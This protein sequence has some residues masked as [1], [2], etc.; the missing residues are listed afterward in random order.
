MMISMNRVFL[1]VNLAPVRLLAAT[2]N[3]GFTPSRFQGATSKRELTPKQKEVA[4]KK[5]LLALERKQI[6][7]DKKKLASLKARLAKE[8]TTYAA[9]KKKYDIANKKNKEKQKTQQLKDKAKLA[10]EKTKAKKALAETK[11]KEDKLIAKAIKPFRK[12]SGYNYFIKEKTVGKNGLSEVSSIWKT[13]AHDE[14]ESYQ[15]KAAK[16]NDE[17]LKIFVPRPKSPP[18]SYASFVKENYPN[19]GGDFKQ[20]NKDLAYEWKL[21][22]VE[23]KQRY[24][25]SPSSKQEYVVKLQQ[26]KQNRIEAFKKHHNIS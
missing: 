20:I 2:R 18:T 21:L 5:K 4:E 13:L 26:W 17:M 1:N 10:L 23:E 25:P 19:D 8:K 11:K 14:K 15:E 7:A 6:A 3:F 16:F 12:L 24:E 22:P 9:L